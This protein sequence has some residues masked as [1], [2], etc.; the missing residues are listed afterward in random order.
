MPDSSTAPLHAEAAR[1]HFLDNFKQRGELGASVSVWSASGEQLSL[2]GGFED[3]AKTRPWT[4]ASRV[5]VWSATKGPSAA[6]V[7]H[8]LTD[9]RLSLDTPVAKLWPE[10]AAA[11]KSAVTVRMILQHQ[12]GLCALDSPPSVYEREAVVAALAA[13]PPAWEPGTAHGYHPRTF[14]FLVDELMRRLNGFSL[15][16]YWRR[17]F[18]EPLDLDFHIGLPES[19][20]DN[21]APMQSPKGTLPKDDPFLTAFMTP[22]SLT[23]RSFASPK[24]LHSASTMNDAQ[25]RRAEFP[26]WGGIGTAEG[27]AKFYALLAGDGCLGSQRLFSQDTLTLI[28]G[29]GTQG[30]DRVLQMETCFSLGFMRDPLSPDGTK[31]RRT[32]GPSATAFGHPGAGGSVAF[33]DP[34]RG[35][36]FAYVMNQMEPGVLPNLKSAGLWAALL[37]DPSESRK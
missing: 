8:A 17:I 13:Q 7:L 2:A 21:V 32:F 12:A 33:A 14:G 35:L 9:A 27:L 4:A 29:P 28:R 26:G 6:C 20:Q 36:G 3:S 5:L 25:A 11:G 24:G 23:S 34:E 19:L 15:G 16:H 22:G 10:F 30:I 37:E 1:A 18:A 31:I